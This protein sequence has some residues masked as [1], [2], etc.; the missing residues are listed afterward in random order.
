MLRR[1]FRMIDYTFYF[2]GWKV[3]VDNKEV[4]I[5]FQDPKYRGVITYGVP[6]GK[7]TILLKFTNTKNTI[8]S[9]YT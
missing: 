7:H 3:F 5:E 1:R 9:K 8:I 2:P 4:P 6:S